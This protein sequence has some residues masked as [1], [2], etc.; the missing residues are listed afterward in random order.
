MVV[1]HIESLVVVGASVSAGVPLSGR[2][3]MGKGWD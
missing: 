1:N 3:L 2:V